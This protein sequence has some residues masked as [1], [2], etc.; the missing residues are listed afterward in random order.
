MRDELV[1]R[2]DSAERQL[3]ALQSEVAELR[4]LA[5]SPEPEAAAPAPTPEALVPPPPTTRWW[6]DE[7]GRWHERLHWEEQE[8]E[9]EPE[10]APV[11]AAAAQPEREP[12]VWQR[13]IRLDR[14]IQ[15]DDLLGAKGLA[16]AGGV[17]TLLG[18]VFF[19]VLAVNRGWIGP[20]MR[21]GLGAAASFIVFAAGVWVKR[22]YG[23]LYAAFSAVGA[24]LAGGY[25]TLLAATA[26]YDFLPEA[27]A[28]AVAAGIA[29]VGLALALA[30]ES[31]TLAS[32]GLIG[33]M[34]VPATLVL[35]GG[36]T[37]IG[38]AFAAVVFG[39]AA[40]VAIR[41]DWR[42]LLAV[43]VGVSLLQIIGLAAYADSV[44]SWPV[45]AVAAAL[46]LLYLG[47]GVGW[48]LYRGAAE[49]LDRIATSLTMLSAS[50]AVLAT[51]RLFEGSWGRF[52]REGVAMAAIA[53][54]EGAAAAFFRRDG[55][56]DLAALHGGIALAVVAIAA[57]DLL[58][59]ANLTYV[60]AAEAALLGWLSWRARE[61]SFQLASLAY[62]V[63]AAAHALMFEARPDRLFE[64]GEHPARAIPSAVALGIA[65]FACAWF[66]RRFDEPQEHAGLLGQIV[67]VLEEGQ[68]ELRIATGC[69][70]AMAGI[71]ALSLGILAVVA[72][73]V[74]GDLERR[75]ELG[76]I[77]VSAAWGLVGLAAALVALRR[78]SDTVLVAAA[79]WFGVALVKVFVFDGAELSDNH[80]SFSFLAVGACLLLAGYLVQLLDERLVRLNGLVVVAS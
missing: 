53:A 65:A 12:S 14:E 75:F 45:I 62:L 39:A 35:E 70:A 32:I 33:A 68:R 72:D 28:L 66:A 17:V 23:A 58:S 29:A 49:G 60:W 43:G 31:E 57:A 1:E 16:W 24:G 78:R 34:F 41:Q 55:R 61:R 22:R 19:F 8:P 51:V 73:S 38:T 69:A 52:D 4:R 40:A 64:V 37:T 18:V 46:W 10:E 54:V 15:L 3:R 63:L 2:L 48:Q 67:A 50:L 47:A 6:Q 7:R 42:G 79:A 76:H 59:G 9:P 77:G 56:R 26:L 71:Y 80:R 11:A 13:E 21:V 74:G 25:A 20:G 30:W 5:V 36:L 44:L 27:G